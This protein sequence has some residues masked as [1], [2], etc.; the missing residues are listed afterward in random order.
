MVYFKFLLCYLFD[1]AALS[2]QY[3]HIK[4]SKNA[5]GTLFSKIEGKDGVITAYIGKKSLTE[6]HFYAP[7]IVGREYIALV[8]GAPEGPHF[9]QQ[10]IPLEFNDVKQPIIVRVS[11]LGDISPQISCSDLHG[12]ELL[13]IVSESDENYRKLRYRVS[14][15]SLVEVSFL[16]HDKGFKLEIVESKEKPSQLTGYLCNIQVKPAKTNSIKNIK[17]YK[18]WFC[19]YDGQCLYTEFPCFLIDDFLVATESCEIDNVTLKFDH[20]NYRSTVCLKQAKDKFAQKLEAQKIGYCFYFLNS[21][22]DKYYFTFETLGMTFRAIAWQNELQRLG[23]E[24]DKLTC[25]D[26][27][28][29]MLKVTLKKEKEQLYLGIISSTCTNYEGLITYERSFTRNK[30]KNLVFKTQP[31]DGNQFIIKQ[32]ELFAHSVIDYIEKG[33]LDRVSLCEFK[34]NKKSAPEWKIKSKEP[35]A[36]VPNHHHQDL[37]PF[38]GKAAHDWYAYSQEKDS[39]FGKVNRDLARYALRNHLVCEVISQNVAH[40]IFIPAPLLK[41]QGI[42]QIGAGAWIRGKARLELLELFTEGQQ[43]WLADS[44]EVIEDGERGLS[45]QRSIY[46]EEL[47]FV[48][49]EASQAFTYYD[50]SVKADKT[51]HVYHL[52]S[53]DKKR[54]FQFKDYSH[55][56]L[57]ISEPECYQYACKIQVNG[58]FNNVKEIL[59]GKLRQ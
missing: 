44:C 30:I 45:G 12:K 15:N 37:V 19:S 58:Q 27:V 32:P 52:M 31:F 49:E 13:R 6:N 23:I 55:Q 5:N 41:L 51:V 54:T 35:I 38:E 1:G 22:G 11:Y 20:E 21:D 25:D 16:R 48:C 56:L 2:L 46:I 4:L 14:H 24:C 8:K 59:S 34:K 10:L 36:L 53:L 42:T 26:V 17:W 7:L 40:M 50:E 3:Y 9:I 18:A 29:G 33:A 57:T 28:E 39:P 43:G 47:T